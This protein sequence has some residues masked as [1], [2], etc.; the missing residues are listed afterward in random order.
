VDGEMLLLNL[1]LGGVC[2]SAGSACTSGA[3][4]P[5]HVLTAIGLDRET[6]AAALRCSLGTDNTEAD[7]DRTIDV[8]AGVV[9]RLRRPADPVPR[10][11]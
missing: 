10:E 3:L 11:A 1:D 2:A 4:E 5:S 7:V 9:A 6:A 8:V